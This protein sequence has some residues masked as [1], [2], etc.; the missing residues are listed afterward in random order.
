MLLLLLLLAANSAM[1][2]RALAMSVESR[3]TL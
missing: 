2:L 3:V 1:T